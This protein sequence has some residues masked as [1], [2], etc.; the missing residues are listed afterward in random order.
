MLWSF[1]VNWPNFSQCPNRRKR[2][3][4]GRFNGLFR[5]N[6]RSQSE[7]ARLFTLIHVIPPARLRHLR[8][9]Y[10]VTAAEQGTASTMVCG[11]HTQGCNF[12]FS[13]TQ[14]LFTDHTFWLLQTSADISP[15]L[16]K[17]MNFLAIMMVVVSLYMFPTCYRNSSLLR[18]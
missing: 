9:V 10:I 15:M 16:S 7:R 4:K 18:A 12:P 14:P 2:P 3:R 5:R 13:F 1:P 11:R 8:L 6:G 17:H